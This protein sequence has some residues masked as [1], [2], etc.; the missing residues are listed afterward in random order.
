MSIDAVVIT[1]ETAR[2]SPW[3]DHASRL[4]VRHLAKHREQRPRPGVSQPGSLSTDSPSGSLPAPGRE[5]GRPTRQLAM[6]GAGGVDLQR[7]E[8]PMRARLER[9]GGMGPHVGAT[10]MMTTNDLRSDNMGS[11]TADDT[12]TFSTARHT[13]VE[14]GRGPRHRPTRQTLGEPTRRR[15]AVHQPSR[16]RPRREARSP[17]RAPRA[18]QTSRRFRTSSHRSSGPAPNTRAPPA[19]EQILAVSTLARQLPLPVRNV[20]GDLA[21]TN[22][23]LAGLQLQLPASDTTWPAGQGPGIRQV[24]GPTGSIRSSRTSRRPGPGRAA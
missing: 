15:Q 14:S 5:P 7:G 1:A 24:R 12:P 11:G 2:R 6:P 17:T 10:P 20:V 9:A 18:P 22:R 23:L 3:P 4:I 8:D 13:S 21:D 19:Y 16:S